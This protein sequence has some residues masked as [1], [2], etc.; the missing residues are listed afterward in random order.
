MEP[1]VLKQMNT[2]YSTGIY[3]FPK[4]DLRAEEEM[5]TPHSTIP[6]TMTQESGPSYHIEDFSDPNIKSPEVDKR[7]RRKKKLTKKYCD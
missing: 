5:L 6:S 1:N 7:P 3:A 4:E 2:Y